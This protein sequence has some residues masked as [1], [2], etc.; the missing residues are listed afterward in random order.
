[1]PEAVREPALDEG[2]VIRHSYTPETVNEILSE[3]RDRLIELRETF[4]IIAGHR[5]RVKSLAGRNG[6]IRKR[7][8]GGKQAAPLPDTF[9]GSPAGRS[10]SGTSSRAWSTSPQLVRDRRSFSVG[11]WERIGGLLA[12]HEPGLAGRQPL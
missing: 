8:S 12:R 2:H 10:W 1:M 7:T 6:G 9:A 5:V 4:A 11:G 3:V